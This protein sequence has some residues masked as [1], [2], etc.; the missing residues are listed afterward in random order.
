MTVKYYGV[1]CTAL[2]MQNFLLSKGKSVSPA[3]A[4]RL[5]TLYKW[6]SEKPRQWESV[7]AVSSREKPNDIYANLKDSTYSDD[8][9]LLVEAGLIFPMMREATDKESASRALSARHGS[10]IVDMFVDPDS[11]QKLIEELKQINPF[12]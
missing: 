3:R 11:R 4:S 1:P 9:R 7:H 5:T 2:T 10:H 8:V 6:F 12:S